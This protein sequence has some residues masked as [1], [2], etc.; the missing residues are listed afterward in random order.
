M[1]SSNC[2]S[3][4]HSLSPVPRIHSL[5]WLLYPR[6]PPPRYAFRPGDYLKPGEDDIEGLK[7]RLDERLAPTS[8]QFD[9]S[10]GAENDWE[11]GDCISQWFRPNFETFMVSLVWI[12]W[13]HQADFNV[14]YVPQ[15][16]FVPPHITKAKE[17]KKLFIVTMPERSM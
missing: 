6:H 7:R 5:D 12:I 14:E 2:E 11:I 4:S 16:P 1:R 10:Q 3:V 8:G 9:E 17:C 15:Y 13:C